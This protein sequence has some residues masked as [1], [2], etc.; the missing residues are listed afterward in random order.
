[1]EENISKNYFLHWTNIVDQNI[2]QMLSLT[3]FRSGPIDHKAGSGFP[4]LDPDTLSI[5]RIFPTRF[6]LLLGY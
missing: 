1:M 6:L 5:E 2:Y 4:Q 3:E